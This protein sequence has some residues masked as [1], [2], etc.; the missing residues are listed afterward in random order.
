MCLHSKM[1]RKSLLC[2]FVS[3]NTWLIFCRPSLRKVWCINSKRQKNC[4]WCFFFQSLFQC[5]NVAVLI[6]LAL[7]LFMK[8]QLEQTEEL[9]SIV[10]STKDNVFRW[11]EKWVTSLCLEDSWRLFGYIISKHVRQR[12]FPSKQLSDTR[13]SW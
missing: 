4:K 12:K 13:C 8:E 7:K 9:P 6:V 5:A 10:L 3:R 2:I 11:L 1:N